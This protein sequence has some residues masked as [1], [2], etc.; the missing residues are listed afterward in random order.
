MHLRI[1][2][3]VGQGNFPLAKMADTI[4]EMSDELENGTGAAMLANIPVHKYS[5]EEVSLFLG[6]FFLSL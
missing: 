1:P 5:V 3:N 4:A 2:M 6:D